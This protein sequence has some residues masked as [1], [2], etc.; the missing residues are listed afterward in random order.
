MLKITPALCLV[1]LA[2]AASAA[3]STA[4]AAPAATADGAAT[5]AAVPRLEFNRQAVVRDLPLFWVRDADADSTLD[6]D[7]LA[8]TWGPGNASLDRYVKDGSFTPEFAA[9]YALIAK[10]VSLDG[11]AAAENTRRQAVLEELGQGRPTLVRTTLTDSRDAQL[12]GHLESTAR[13][14]ERLFAQAER[15]PRPRRPHPGG[16]HRFERALLPQPG[17]VLRSAEDGE[18]PELQRTGAAAEE[19]LRHVPGIDPGRRRFLHGAREARGCRCAAQPVLDRERKGRR[20][21]HGQPCHGRTRGRPLP[22]RVRGR[23][24]GGQQRVARCRRTAGRGSVRGARSRRTWRP[25]HR[26]SSTAAGSRP[27]SPGRR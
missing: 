21:R 10:P 19:N 11:L 12:V 27:T 1:L 24:E 14:I 22:G 5:Y 3:E 2:N 9:A 8:V 6:P 23:H 20:T 7:E 25:P 18:R 4:A 16:R 15:R 17:P 26:R 13:I